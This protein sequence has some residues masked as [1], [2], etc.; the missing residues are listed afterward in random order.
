MPRLASIVDAGRTL[1]ILGLE[2]DADEET[3]A[4]C[5]AQ[6]PPPAPPGARDGRYTPDG[7]RTRAAT[8]KGWRPRPLVDG[9]EARMQDTAGVAATPSRAPSADDVQPAGSRRVTPPPQLWTG[10]PKET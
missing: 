9:G 8:L 6:S 3:A 4:E 5:D 10:P 7:I 2:R 1:H